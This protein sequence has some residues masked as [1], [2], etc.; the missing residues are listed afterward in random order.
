MDDIVD[1]ILAS[2]EAHNIEK[3]PGVPLTFKYD[4]I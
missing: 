1:N 3:K 4:P 2:A